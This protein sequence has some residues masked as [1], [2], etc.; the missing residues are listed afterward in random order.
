MVEGLSVAAISYHVVGLVEH[1]VKEAHD[2]GRL[3]MELSFITAAC[4]PITAKKVWHRTPWE[5]KPKS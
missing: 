5:G 2:T 4:A 1:L 3:T